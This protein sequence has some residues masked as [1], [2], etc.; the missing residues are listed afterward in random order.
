MMSYNICVLLT[1]CVNPSGM[2][3]TTL[4]N[5]QIRAEQ[6]KEA[7]NY[8]LK[9][10]SLP[11]VF[12]ENT[13]Y[14]ISDVF[15]QYIASGRLEYLTFNGNNYDKSKGK[16]YGEALIM[17]YAINHS[18]VI[19][20][21]KY[22]IKITGRLIIK[23]IKRISSSPLLL[24]DNLFRCNI[25]DKFIST[26]IFIARPLLVLKFVEKYQ[27]MIREDSPT[28]DL[29][30]HHLYRALTKDS[31]ICHTTFVPFISIPKVVGISG[32]TGEPYSMKDRL[33]GNLAYAFR[34]EMDRNN[35]VLALSYLAAYYV[36][37][38]CEKL[39]S[40]FG[41]KRVPR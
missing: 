2:S 10:T 8:Y 36:I 9:E 13:M 27:E 26:Y 23:D 34:F 32:T 7:L 24:Y 35:K 30:E 19:K 11:I 15:Q 3:H 18:K 40:K 29:I 14:D 20:N 1:A 39:K 33:T 17:K 31:E 38:Y 21:C 37:Y 12:C 22:L 28:N 41:K 16:G 4:Q 6:Y 25:K 5:P